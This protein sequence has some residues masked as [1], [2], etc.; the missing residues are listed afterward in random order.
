MRFKT[1][2]NIPVGVVRI[3]T[4]R[5]HDAHSVVDQL[6][7]GHPDADVAMVCREEQR[8]LITLDLDFS[9]VRLYPPEQ[10]PGLVILRPGLQSI[11]AI[12]RLAEQLVDYLSSQTLTGHLWIVEEHRL[13]IR[14]K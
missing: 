9:D 8:A 5:G 11:S 12:E 10:F 7:D 2:E 1:D 4:E 3:L 13:R 14:G 6:L